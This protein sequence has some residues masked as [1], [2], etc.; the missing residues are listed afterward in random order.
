MT[1][2][3]TGDELTAD[4]L[5]GTDVPAAGIPALMGHLLAG[6]RFAWDGLY[7][8]S[9][10]PAGGLLVTRADG[11][12]SFRAGDA[13]EA[14]DMIAADHARKPMARMEAGVLQQ[15][16]DFQR[17]HPEVEWTAPSYSHKATWKDSGGV[18]QEE[19]APTAG[20][21]LR[22]LRDRGMA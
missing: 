3:A 17:A 6:L 22:R 11:Y 13:L 21:L 16:I 10:H 19:S 8:I 4:A 1:G 18:A 12:G 20:L 9:G 15:R 5:A 14:R 2:Q 7:L